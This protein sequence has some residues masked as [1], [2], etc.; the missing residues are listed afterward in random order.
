MANIVEFG[1]RGQVSSNSVRITAY[2]LLP[3]T[4]HNFIKEESDKY[5][6]KYYKNETQYNYLRNHYYKSKVQEVDNN[7]RYFRNGS[8]KF[9]EDD[10][11]SSL[12]D[13]DTEIKM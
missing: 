9:V 13:L 11:L 5:I 6:K 2:Y 12:L 1:K 8:N 10:T 3:F 4:W 7:R